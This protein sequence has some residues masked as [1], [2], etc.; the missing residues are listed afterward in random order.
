MSEKA[1]DD[2]QQREGKREEEINSNGTGGSGDEAAA[3]PPPPAAPTAPKFRHDWYQTESNVCI[4]ILIKK[5]K[6]ENVHVDFQEK[7]VCKN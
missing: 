7:M 5:V 3:S 4:S 1:G 6:Q 2:S